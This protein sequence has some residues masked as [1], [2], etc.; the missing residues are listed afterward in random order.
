MVWALDNKPCVLIVE[1]DPAFL[2]SL[3]RGTAAYFKAASARSVDAALEIIDGGPL[4]DAAIVD[5][6][7]PDGDGFQVVEALR[8]DHGPAAVMILTGSN[9]AACINRANLLGAEYVC[10]PFFSE[11]LARFIQRVIA[12]PPIA[13][14]NRRTAKLM[15]LH[16]K[17]NLTEHEHAMLHLI[18]VGASSNRWARSLG[19][20]EAMVEPIATRLMRKLAVRSLAEVERI[21]REQ[22]D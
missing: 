13:S 16:E 15:A 6:G 1:D 12:S 20:G 4:I 7:L 11:N 14:R 2:R 22:I 19:I 17:H 10:K 18:A 21:V 5:L 8:K 9:D 3:L